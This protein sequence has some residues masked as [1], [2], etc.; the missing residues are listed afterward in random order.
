MLNNSS[1]T[2]FL[3]LYLDQARLKIILANLKAEDKEI[4]HY[5]L[6]QII[7]SNLLLKLS[8]LL[9]ENKLLEFFELLSDKRSSQSTLATWL[10]KNIVDCTLTMQEVIDKT[11]FALK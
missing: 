7:I 2:Q 4:C 8:S 11:L 5:Y 3:N 1:L 10:D 9:D 6:E